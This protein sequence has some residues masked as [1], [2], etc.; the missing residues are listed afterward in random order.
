MRSPDTLHLVVGGVNF[1]LLLVWAIVAHT[2]WTSVRRARPH[3]SF[4]QQPAATFA[5]VLALMA[6][7]LA[8]FYSVD[9]LGRLLPR[10]M[11]DR[12]PAALVP[13]YVLSEWSVIAAVALF[14]HLSWFFP[15]R[16]HRLGR[17]WLAANY[18]SAMLVGTLPVLFRTVTTH[19]PEQQWIPYYLLIDTYFIAMMALALR[20]LA[21]VARRGFWRPGAGAAMARRADVLVIAWFLLALGGWM[22]VFTLMGSAALFRSD[23]VDWMLMLLGVPIAVPFAARM[24]GEVVRGVLMTMALLGGAAAVY[25][26]ARAFEPLVG[27]D[28]GYLFEV[29]TIVAFVLVL[30]PGH[31]WVRNATDRLVFRRRRRRQ[32]D[33]Q[34]FMSVLSPELGARECCRRAL[35]ELSRI[36]ELRGTGIFLARDEQW[37]VHGDR[38]RWECC[39]KGA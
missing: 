28:L 2:S 39:R 11:F 1:V 12:P 35:A 23:L 9:T 10:E 13:L 4:T 33:L 37:V 14:R 6:G 26:G 7:A 18:G 24:L 36:M 25:L 27:P 17:K 8:L 21:Q 30:V 15:I 19:T 22:I 34:A 31:G 16:D 5:H 32:A 38:R 3:I 20:R 29:G